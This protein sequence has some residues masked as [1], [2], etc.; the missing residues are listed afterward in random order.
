MEAFPVYPK[1]CAKYSPSGYTRISS[2]STDTPFRL[3]SFSLITATIVSLTF[4][5]IVVDLYFFIYFADI[6]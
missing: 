2:V 5:H 6:E 3:S 1:I 4:L